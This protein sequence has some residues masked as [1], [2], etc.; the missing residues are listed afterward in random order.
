MKTKQYSLE[1]K[2]LICLT[3]AVIATFIGVAVKTIVPAVAAARAESNNQ[4]GQ[5]TRPD[6]PETPVISLDPNLS[7]ENLFTEGE[8]VFAGG[9]ADGLYIVYNSG[10]KGG[11]YKA[12]RTL[13]VVSSIALGGEAVAACLTDDGGLA[14]AIKKTDGYTVCF[15]DKYGVVTENNRV[16]PNEKP[17]FAGCYDGDTAVIFTSEGAAG[18]RIIFR[19]FRSGEEICE[20]YANVS[21]TPEPVE[22]YR[23]GGVFTMFY[24]YKS[25]FSSGGGYAAFSMSTVSVTVTGIERSGGYDFLSVIPRKGSFAMLCSS[26]DGAFIMQL[27]ENYAR[28]EKFDVTDYSVLRGKLSYDGK[29]YFAFVGGDSQGRMF[30]FNDEMT[31]KTPVDVYS[32]ATEIAGEFNTGG[33]LLHLLKSKNGFFLA[34][35]NGLFTKKVTKEGA[36]PIALV[37]TDGSVAAVCNLDE[38]GKTSVYAALFN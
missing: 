19:L 31:E 24:K 22:I 2:A 7:C 28:S 13:S 14:A 4:N 1:S 38:D 29:N 15:I 25:E 36:V 34:D 6:Q 33:T 32:A 3:I 10:G 37:K 5:I 11:V 8:A 35:T 27:D 9:T 23:V 16:Y 26:P 12:G 20:R 17:V 30:R 21:Y 18:K